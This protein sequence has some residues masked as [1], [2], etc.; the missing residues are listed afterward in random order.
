VPQPYLAVISLAAILM[1]G[2]ALIICH[3]LGHYLAA[4]AA[5]VMVERFT[6]GIGP[7]LFR[8]KDRTGTVWSLSVFPVG[9][10]VSF[11]GERDR[12]R[13]GGYA[14]LRPPARM[15][16]VLAGP[17]ANLL[18]AVGLYA[19]ILAG[20][21]EITLLP[22]ATTIEAGSP[23]AHAGL[24][25]GDLIVSANGT[26]ISSFSDL[27][28]WLRARPNETVDLR[29]ER[30]GRQFEV[31]P[32]LGSLETGGQ[33]VGV[34]GIQARTL[35]HRQ[36]TIGEIL[37]LAPARAWDVMVLTVTGIATAITTGQGGGQFTGMLGVAHMAGEAASSGPIQLLALTAVLSINL[38]L[39]N[40]LPIPVLDGGAFLFCLFE[41][42]TGRPASARAQDLATRTGVAA[43]AG[44]FALST[45]H[46]LA[47]LGLIQWLPK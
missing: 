30:Q 24:K 44:L 26:V 15:M 43:I 2:N 23:A 19:C 31:T 21:G 11:A 42:L 14:A 25:E 1:I 8:L 27:G 32:H 46:D 41:W 39:M 3:E 18:V 9:G 17:A 5:G 4:R 34:L 12:S 36:L 47:G 13:Q 37:A 45:F 33:R 28:A 10:F 16:I 29:V 22:V 20:R 7:N 38:V 35:G 6:I 40:L